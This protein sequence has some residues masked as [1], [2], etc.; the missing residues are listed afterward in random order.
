MSSYHA[1]DDEGGSSLAPS[2]SFALQPA[3][4]RQVHAQSIGGESTFGTHFMET[5]TAGSV[6]PEKLSR[7]DV[8]RS[9][10]HF[11]LLK[12]ITGNRLKWN[13]LWVLFIW[14]VCGF[15]IYAPYVFGCAAAWYGVASLLSFFVVVWAAAIVFTSYYVIFLYRGMDKDYKLTYPK[16]TVCYHIIV[17]TI[18]KVSGRW[19]RV[20]AIIQCTSRCERGRSFHRCAI[21]STLMCARC[22]SLCCAQDDMEVVMRTVGSIAK[23]TEAKR[24][25]ML[26]AWEGRTP[27]REARTAQMK[28]AFSNSFHMLLFSVHPFR[29]P[30]EIASKAASVCSSLFRC[31]SIVE[32]ALSA[33]ADCIRFVCCVPVSQQRQLGPAL[34]DSSPVR[35]CG[36]Q[37][38]QSFHGHGQSPLLSH[39][40]C[41]HRRAVPSVSLVLPCCATCLLLCRPATATL[42]STSVTSRL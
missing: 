40:P 28:A 1:L 4:G 20:P 17:L 42:F 27:D 23:Q 13:L 35:A 2:Q 38:R 36:S 21:G 30:H 3:K 22:V 31:A 7:D 25:V 33:V 12:P 14:I 29:L 6:L 16:E 18:Y 32:C 11:K 26:L 19:A 34:R 15:P 39:S 8:I 9:A 41:M 10:R 24:I 37:E 5:L